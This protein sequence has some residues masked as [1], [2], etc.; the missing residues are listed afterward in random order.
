MRMETINAADDRILR[1]G[2]I[3]N[4]MWKTLLILS[5]LS[6]IFLTFNQNFSLKGTLHSTLFVFAIIVCMA[7][8]AEYIDS[9]L[10]MGYGTTLTPVLIILGYSPLEIVPAVLLS[11]F[12]SG[13]TAGIMHH[14]A[15]NVD[16][17]NN[18]QARNIL[19]IM[20]LCS[21]SGT[22]AA[23]FL[24]LKL[25]S[26]YVKLY[27][28]VM[29]LS[30]GLLIT[31]GQKLFN[32]FSWPKIIA[33]G[34]LAAFNKG[35]SGGGYGPLVTGGQVM[36]GVDEKVSISV[37]SLAEGSVCLVGFILYLIFKGNLNWTLTIPLV[38]GAILSVPAAVITVKWLPRS[39]IKSAIGYVTLFL[40]TL[41]LIRL[42]M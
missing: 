29:I 21:V 28:G 11:E 23:V 17:V 19:V 12:I 34:L 38:L 41:A 1:L 15:D 9:S 18:K 16:F 20:T 4:V 37:T 22:L 33:I 10:G 5:G 35:I 39:E 14:K 40:G 2:K 7:F 32:R 36:S 24:A 6:L 3:C 26:F 30:I 31:F 25:P 42:Y 8:V 27:I 13:T